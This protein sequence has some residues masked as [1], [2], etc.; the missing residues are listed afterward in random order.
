MSLRSYEEFV[1][2]ACLLGE[3]DPVQAWKAVG[4]R[5]ARLV[6]WMMPRREIHII[7]PGTDLRLSVAGRTWMNDDGHKNFPGGEIFTA[8]IENS[9]HGVVEFSFPA[10]LGGREIEGVRLVFEDGVV[11]DIR[12]RR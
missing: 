10:F 4:E 2:K 5:Q 9:V 12:A 6:D 7:A 11:T 3:P 1:Y 8:P